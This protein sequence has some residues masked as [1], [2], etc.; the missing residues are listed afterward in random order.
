MNV[1]IKK[2]FIASFAMSYCLVINAEEGGS[3]HY[4]PGSISSFMDGV[5]AKPSFI[6]RLNLISY[7]GEYKPQVSILGLNNAIIKVESQALALT[8][9][10]RPHFEIGEGWSY[11]FG[12]TIPFINVTTNIG[13]NGQSNVNITEEDSGIGD[14]ILAPVM[15]NQ[16]INSDLN[17][18]YRVSIYAPTGG[19]KEGQLANTGK[20]Y[21]TIEPTV[22]AVYFGKEN[23]IEAS[24]YA[25]V[26]F[27][28]ENHETSY[29]SGTQGHV[30]ATFGQSFPF[31]GGLA[32]VGATGF[33]YQQL[34]GDS[35]SGAIFGDFKAKTV[36][37]GPR[38]SF[39]HNTERGGI[40]M[41]LKWFHEFETE[42]RTKGGTIFLKALA[43]F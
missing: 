9:A 33:Y 43:K 10:Y 35:G 19:Y 24:V 22:G 16:N 11:A 3:G 34:T 4:Q 5:P 6:T 39:V 27:N 38:V 28:T 25:G 8:M 31:F 20:N 12:G 40:A 15:L 32:S 41:E 1:I 17:L 21:W 14:V 36:G 13:V 18:N 2:T 37:A 30:E 23:G 7:K 42:R 29:Q 26:D